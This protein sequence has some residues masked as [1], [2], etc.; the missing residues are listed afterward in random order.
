MDLISQGTFGYPSVS[1]FLP[2]V[3]GSLGAIPALLS[4]FFDLD[5]AGDSL[6]AASDNPRQNIY[7]FI[8]GK[9][10]LM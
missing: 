4:L 10:R 1:W 8:I 6:R 3:Y 9:K 7:D 2:I 5:K